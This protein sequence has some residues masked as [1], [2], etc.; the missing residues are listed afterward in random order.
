[1]LGIVRKSDRKIIAIVEDRAAAKHHDL[2]DCV[3]RAVPDG[4]H[5]K[6]LVWD[7][8]K[9]P[10][11]E[12]LESH[13]Q[14][15]RLERS[16]RLAASDPAMLPDHPLFGDPAVAAYRAALRDLPKNTTDP[17]NPEWPEK[18]AGL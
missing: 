9:G 13:W 3:L 7:G 4:C 2:T 15:L 8:G 6:P 17:K 11:V 5:D 10:L 1:M 12:C 14:S 18:P 16:A